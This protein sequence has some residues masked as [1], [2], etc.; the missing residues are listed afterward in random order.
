MGLV[1]V[2][3]GELDRLLDKFIKGETQRETAPPNTLLATTSPAC[4][5]LTQT[6][7]VKHTAGCLQH[8]GGD[9]YRDCVGDETERGGGGNRTKGKSWLRDLAFLSLSRQAAGSPL[10][11]PQLPSLDFSPKKLLLEG[12]T[13]TSSSLH[14]HPFETKEA[15]RLLIQ[16]DCRIQNEAGNNINNAH[17]SQQHY[18]V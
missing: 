7:A 13:S 10:A 16:D 2:G 12:C 8:H 1:V 14:L 6:E 18:F 5:A 4:Q 11:A 9:K 15:S 3:V 17:Y